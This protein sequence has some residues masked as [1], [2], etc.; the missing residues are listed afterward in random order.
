MLITRYFGSK[1]R[2]F[3]EVVERAFTERT[4]LGSDRATLSRD[5]ANALTQRTGAHAARQ[6]P[7][8][9]MLNSAADPRAAEI[10]REQIEA[11]VEQHAAGVLGGRD[12][13]ERAALLLSIIAGVLLMRTV[14]RE[15]TLVELD[16]GQLAAQLERLFDAIIDPT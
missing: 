6:D 10:L 1:E 5:I 4:M 14:I 3:A 2:L 11:Q 8:R 16:D 13:H 12:A 15:T 7:F 9:L